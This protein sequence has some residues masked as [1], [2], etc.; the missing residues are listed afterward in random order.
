M[1]I[2]QAQQEHFV[3]NLPK[4]QRIQLPNYTQINNLTTS[5]FREKNISKMTLYSQ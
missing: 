3:L 5:H 1:E 4:T 2:Y